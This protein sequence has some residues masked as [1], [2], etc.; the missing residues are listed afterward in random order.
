MKKTRL[1][2]SS[3]KIE[4]KKENKTPTHAAPEHGKDGAH[5]APERKKNAEKFY[6]PI[7]PKKIW[8]KFWLPPFP[9]KKPI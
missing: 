5:R 1:S 4:D 7:H 8:K 3:L 6:L 2:F 9:R